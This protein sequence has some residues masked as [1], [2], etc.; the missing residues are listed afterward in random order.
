MA[1]QRHLARAPITEAIIDL[2]AKLPEGFKPESF[3]ALK[4]KLRETYPRVDEQ[5]GIEGGLQIEKGQISQFL[6]EFGL[7]G[8]MFRSEGGEN[9]AQ[10]RVDGFTFS[11]LKP[12][13]SWESIFPEALSLWRLYAQT[14]SPEFI[15]RLALRYINHLKLPVPVRD[16]SEYL[17]APPGVPPSLPGELAGFVSR[18]VVRDVESK[19]EATVTQLTE[20]V[21]DTKSMILLL[22]IDVYKTSQL[23]INEGEIKKEFEDLHQ[24]KNRIFFN[25]I[26]EE[27]V[28]LFA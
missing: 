25:S 7:V 10:F 5:R 2:R 28:R 8:L 13:T 1:S 12:Y 24:T 14:A 9:V 22:D 23:E 4:D 15:T 6:K 27:T 18:I 20:R 26:T 17:T 3:S 16:L 11:R 21:V 19:T